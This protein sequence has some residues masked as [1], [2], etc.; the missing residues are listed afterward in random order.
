MAKFCTYCGKQLNETS[1]FCSGCGQRVGQS[2]HNEPTPVPYAQVTPIQ[3]NN[4]SNALPVILAIVLIVQLTAIILFGKPG[5]L[6]NEK[7][8]TN[9]EFNNGSSIDGDI[10]EFTGGSMGNTIGN[11]ND[12]LPENVK[13]DA[14]YDE[15]FGMWTGEIELTK[16]DGFAEMAKM[17]GGPDVSGEIEKMLST[18][19]AIELEIEDTGEWSFNMD[20]G[21]GMDMDS[22][23]FKIREDE[24]TQI[25]GNP[26]ISGL[27]SGCFEVIAGMNQEGQ[28]SMKLNFTG[29]LCEEDGTQYIEGIFDVTATMNGLEIHQQGNYKVYKEE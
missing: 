11:T 18:P 20:V 8:S 16:M 24:P 13:T 9:K 17:Q 27:N 22:S 12:N 14:T 15:L 5:I 7:I 4:E 21:M 10:S 28:G 1:K 26:L 6:I 3:I 29:A 2:M 19:S 25:E 23:M